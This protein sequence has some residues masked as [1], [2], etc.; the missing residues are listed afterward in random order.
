MTP[1]IGPARYKLRPVVKLFDSDCGFLFETLVAETGIVVIF[2]LGDAL[3]AVLTMEFHGVTLYRCGYTPHGKQAKFTK[4]LLT[5]PV[6]LANPDFG[7]E[8]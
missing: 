7:L 6:P 8:R 4:W 3:V 2:S 1:R 5:I